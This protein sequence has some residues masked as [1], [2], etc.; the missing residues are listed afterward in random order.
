MPLY[1]G[2]DLGTT[3]VKAVLVRPDGAIAGIGYREYPIHI[4]NPGYAEQDPADWWRGL[5]EALQEALRISGAPPEQ[6]RGIGLSGQMHGMVLL[7]KERTPLHPAVIWCDQRTVLQAEEIR[8]KI[9]VARLGQ[10]VQNPVGVGFQICSLLWMKRHQPAIYGRT[11]HVLLPKD[12]IRLLLTGEIGSEPTDA[13]STLCYD[14]AGQTWSDAMLGALEIPRALM[15]D[16][17]HRPHEI[18]GQLTQSAADALGLP[19]G[20]AVAYGGGDQPMQAVGNGILHP[21]D[22]SLTLGTGGQVLVPTSTPAYDKLLRTHTFCHVLRDTWYV[23]GAVLN[24]CLAQ[25]WFLEN[26]LRDRNFKQMDLEAQGAVPGCNGLLFLPYLTG[27]RTPHMDPRAKGVFFGLTLGHAR[28]DMVRSVMEGVGF[29]LLDAMEA[30]ESLGL[31]A[32]RLILSGGGAASPLWKQI[33][34]DIF[35]RPIYTSRMREEAGVGAAICAMVACA[36][37]GSVDEACRA[38]V[39]YEDGCVEPVN[40]N[41]EVY[42]EAHAR[43]QALYK[44]CK[45]CF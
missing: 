29:A 32:D 36:Q 33:I 13:C 43:F 37:Y 45:P 44:A 12:Y 31:A 19:P 15:P 7:G 35:G 10:W 3:G 14:C 17:A 21:G 38:I 16:A 18:A 11:R 25:N 41:A 22:A 24:C 39:R 8:A 34:A 27:E 6:I 9:G 4:P 42:R 1:L 40:Q 30:I 23:M 2:I 26:I 20:I 5:K 28:G